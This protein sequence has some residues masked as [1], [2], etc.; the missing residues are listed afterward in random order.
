MAEGRVAGWMAKKKLM[1]VLLT[2]WSP[3][4]SI[5]K[6][7]KKKTAILREKGEKPYVQRKPRCCWLLAAQTLIMV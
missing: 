4:R 3:C 5:C 7:V 6:I 2:R 1:G